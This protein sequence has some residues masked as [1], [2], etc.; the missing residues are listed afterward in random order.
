MSLIHP[1]AIVEKGAQI[2][3]GVKIGAYVFISKDSTLKDGVEIMQGAQIYGKTI[4][5]ENTKI[6][7]YAIVGMPPQDLGYVPEDDVSVEIGKNCVLR[8]FVTVNAG[9][10]S[11]G[12]ITKIGDDCFIMISCHIAHDCKVGDKVIMAN[13]AVLAGH[14]HVGSFTVIGGQTPIH[15][16]VHVGEGVMIG[17]ASAISQD[18]PPYCLAEGNRA[19]VR[20]LNVVG[21]K[22]RF[23]REDASA[24]HSAYKVL[25][26]SS[27][28]I[29]ESATILT[30]ETNNEKV[31]NLCN[32]ILES[33]RG[34][35]F[36]RK[37]DGD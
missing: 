12:G 17:G 7:P 1:S 15:Q 10:K 9:T 27:K 29:K 31:L 8:E 16:F 22:R 30:Q 20:G 35:P 14:V 23:S 32:F 37:N 25:F 33:K 24:L 26:R 11:G 13:N 21:I 6:Y 34:I 19:V 18:I 36:E 2:S 4:V 5:G 3:Q 28:P